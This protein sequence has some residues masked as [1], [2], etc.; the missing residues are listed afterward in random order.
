MTVRSVAVEQMIRRSMSFVDDRLRQVGSRE[1]SDIQSAEEL[2]PKGSE[3]RYLSIAEL[4]LP[5]PQ[6][7]EHE[8]DHLIVMMLTPPRQDGASGRSGPLTVLR[9][10]TLRSSSRET[11]T[12]FFVNDLVV[13]PDARPFESAAVLI[14]AIAR[15]PSAARLIASLQ[16]AVGALDETEDYLHALSLSQAVIDRIEVLEQSGD[17]EIV[18]AG[19]ISGLGGDTAANRGTRFA[20]LVCDQ[21]AT[22]GDQRWWVRGS[23]LQV[24]EQANSAQPVA[25]GSYLLLRYGERSTQSSVRRYI[26]ELRRRHALKR[27]E[28]RAGDQGEAYRSYVDSEVAKRRQ[29]VIDALYGHHT[30]LPVVTPIAVEAAN[31][32]ESVVALGTDPDTELQ[33]LMNTMR[34]ELQTTY[35]VNIP[36][37]RVRLNET[38]LPAGTYIIMINEI[39]LVSGNISLDQRLCDETVDRL[40]LLNI[41]GEKA[42]HP[43]DGHACSWIPQEHAELLQSAGIT[44]WGPAGYV[45]L[46]LESVLRK[47]LSEFM[48]IAEL[49]SGLGDDAEA[50]ELFN[51]LGSARGGAPRFRNVIAAL[52]NEELPARPLPVLARQY[53]ERVDM[54]AYDIAEELRLVDEVNTHL[55]QD[56]EKWWV[57]AVADDF[58]ALLRRHILRREDAAVLAMEPESTQEALAAVR[59]EASNLPSGARRPAILVEDWRIRPFV[60]KLIELEFPQVKVVAR[61]DVEKVDA[62][63][64]RPQ[65]IITME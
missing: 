1:V 32:L 21:I 57:L 44:T 56:V 15:N 41:K 7:A 20:A 35:G 18:L 16:G 29:R 31:N 9:P 60:K 5:R 39:P 52:L 48:G 33:T 51:R 25:G 10:E 43:G 58:V 65:A 36:G 12:T 40:S 3:R 23:N 63:R 46:H 47:N 11:R 38:D 22:G 37:V 61:R 28:L 6:S 49:A 8:R 14:Y 19:R 42:V 24:G 55:I 59:H 54:P 53:L 2:A 13:A 62:D 45:I 30:M 26:D 27:E 4:C 34:K 17:A 64:L 50:K